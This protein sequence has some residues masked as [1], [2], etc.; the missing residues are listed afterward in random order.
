MIYEK[1]NRSGGHL[2]SQYIVKITSKQQYPKLFY[3]QNIPQ[4][5]WTL[6]MISFVNELIPSI[7]LVLTLDSQIGDWSIENVNIKYNM[8]QFKANNVSLIACNNLCK[9]NALLN[10]PYN[11]MVEY[12]YINHYLPIRT[13]LDENADMKIP[14]T[15][16][17]TLM[18]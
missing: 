5:I 7:Q 13:F 4:R 18:E 2:G 1:N 15:M 3:E 6:I 10:Y 16:K 11:I 12:E 17:F 14:T 9:A 8:Y